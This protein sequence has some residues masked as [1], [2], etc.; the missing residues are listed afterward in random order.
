MPDMA[1]ELPLRTGGAACTP[2]ERDG[3]PV[4]DDLPRPD[5]SR[6]SPSSCEPVG[7]AAALAL[8][9]ERLN[10]ELRAQVEELRASRARIVEAGRR[11]AP[12]RSSATS[13][14]APSSGW[15]R[16]R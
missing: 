7:A 3:R 9:N 2:V 5:R 4:G 10:A 12:A 14:T 11:R 16:W 6:R 15:S 13:T 8:E 1:V